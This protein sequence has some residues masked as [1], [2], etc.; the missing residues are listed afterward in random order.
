MFPCSKYHSVTTY[1]VII[2]MTL[3]EMFFY[4]KKLSH[5]AKAQRKKQK[6]DATLY[7]KPQTNV[8][9]RP[10]PPDDFQ[11]QVRN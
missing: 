10:S 3:I 5:R 9:E 6:S 11:V 8:S 7:M 2:L 1:L 4:F